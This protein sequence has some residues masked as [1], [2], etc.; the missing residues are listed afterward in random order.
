VGLLAGA[1]VLLLVLIGGGIVLATNSGDDTTDTTLGTSPTTNTT[2]N[3]ATSTSTRL[4]TSTSTAAPVGTF[5][6]AG[7]ELKFG[8]KALV[9]LKSKG[10]EGTV[11]VTATGIKKGDP[12]DLARLNLGD[13]AAGLTPYYVTFVVSNESG[14]DFAFASTGTMGGQLGDGSRAQSVFAS[15]GFPPCPRGTASRDFTTK[16]TTF[17]TCAL[18]LA[19]GSS[20]VTAATYGGSGAGTGDTDYSRDPIIWK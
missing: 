9:P 18:T 15:T 19:G 20:A 6:K 14:T 13:R 10:V 17:T 8:E 3:P 11:G 12:A 16:G 5:T 7:S 1:L 4:E 2:T